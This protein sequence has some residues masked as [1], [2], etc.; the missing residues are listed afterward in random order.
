MLD[1]PGDEPLPE[2]R[3]IGLLDLCPTARVLLSILFPE[4]RAATGGGGGPARRAEDG[5]MTPARRAHRREVDGVGVRC[6]VCGKANSRV[7]DMREVRNYVRRRR[8]CLTPS[9]LA[10]E[11]DPQRGKQRT[12]VKGVRWTTYEYTFPGRH[13]A[14]VSRATNTTNSVNRSPC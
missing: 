3:R 13:R 9:C 7:I 11:F 12:I 8:L 14:G 10:A 6:P 1:S 5:G 2:L 4:G